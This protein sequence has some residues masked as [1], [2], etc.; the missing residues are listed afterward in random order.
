M[1]YWKE[2]H[3]INYIQNQLNYWILFKNI[4]F[5]RNWK[6]KIV[7]AKFIYK[8]ILLWKWCF[9]MNIDK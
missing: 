4:K 9:I 2:K 6:K 5:N 8:N 3:F 1:N 7:T